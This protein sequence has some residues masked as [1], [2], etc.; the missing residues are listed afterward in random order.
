MA[1]F[2]NF[3][4]F[5][6]GAGSR[7]AGIQTIAPMNYNSS[8]S[9]PI[10]V[11]T[12]L[13]L[14]AVW[15]CV[16]LYAETIGSLPLRLYD[17]NQET[18]EKSLNAQ[19]RLAV[20]FDGKVNRWQ[21]RQEFIETVMFH[22]VLQG[23][24]YCAIQRD[25]AGQI[26]ALIPLVPD[27]MEV[28]LLK[29]GTRVYTYTENGEVKVFAEQNIWHNKLFGNGIVGFSPLAYARTAMGI[30]SAAEIS[31]SKIY[32][33]GG[34][35]SGVLTIDKAL[36]KAQRDAIKENF[37][38]LT[39]GNEDRLFVLEHGMDFKP[40][41]MTPQDIELL[42]CRKF[43]IE[44]IAR[45]FAVPSVL[46]NDTGASTVWGSGVQ[47]IVQGFYKLS[48]RPYLERL[49][50][51]M[52]IW[53]LPV[54]ERSTIEIEFDFNSLLRPDQADRIKTYREAVQGGIITPN[55]ARKG[56]GLK[57][58][59][60]GDSLIVQQQMMKLENIDSVDRGQAQNA[61]QNA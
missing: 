22:L 59:D 34:K 37:S 30:A 48:L 42:A 47:Q 45:F 18:G 50:A 31:E 43:Q 16:R 3:L 58:L 53:L 40:V 5:F 41:S 36:Q 12:A 21:T 51:S 1:V 17:V 55:E 49:E 54:N 46:I 10:T 44:D 24:S 39:E 6:S 56:E 23:N 15:A 13:Q 2:S 61:G 60:G 4:K 28:T 57:P 35:P 38:G 52:K 32:R 14:S 27:Q 20:L 25:T 11:D 29:D 9:V 7:E 19:H 8:P 33:N 26:V